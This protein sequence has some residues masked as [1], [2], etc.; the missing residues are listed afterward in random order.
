MALLGL[1]CWVTSIFMLF[2][3][4]IGFIIYKMIICARFF[5]D[6]VTPILFC[7]VYNVSLCISIVYIIELLLLLA[8]SIF[9]VHNA[10]NC[11]IPCLQCIHLCTILLAHH[12][13]LFYKSF[14]YIYILFMFVFYCCEGVMEQWTFVNGMMDLC[15]FT[16]LVF[17]WI[18]Y[19]K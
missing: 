2:V 10:S 19:Y 8:M 11:A 9:F 14:A 4:L 7:Y 17:E 6:I 3:M 15:Y 12:F 5:H 18:E 13:V 16:I 1:F